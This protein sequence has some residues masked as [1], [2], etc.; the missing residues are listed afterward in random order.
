MDEA[1]RVPPTETAQ[2]LLLR[3]WSEDDIPALL[4]AHQDPLLRRWLRH[5]VTSADQ[6]R[7]MVARHEAARRTG[8]GFSFAVLLIDA[9]DIR[10]GDPIGGVSLRGLDGDTGYGEVGYWTASRARGKGVATRALTAVCAWAFQLPGPRPLAG[11]K[12]I[13]AVGN[14]ASC[15]VA[16]KAGFTFSA[17]LPPLPPE[18]PHDGHLHIRLA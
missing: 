12:L 3:P 11:L 8:S 1:I 2:G 7:D 16:V 15:R 4:T 6:A 18:F 5:P 17:V 9:A 13:H 14:Q 10:A